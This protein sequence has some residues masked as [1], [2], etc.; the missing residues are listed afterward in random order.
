MIIF[1]KNRWTINLV[2]ISENLKTEAYAQNILINEKY[3]RVIR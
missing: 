2:K 1:T 3:R